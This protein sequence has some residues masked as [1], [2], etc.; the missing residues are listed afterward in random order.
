MG[1]H[2]ND[3]NMSAGTLLAAPDFHR[4]MSED[5]LDMGAALSLALLAT[6]QQARSMALHERQRVRSSLKSVG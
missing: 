6:L 2:G 4:A 3:R 5:N 1:G